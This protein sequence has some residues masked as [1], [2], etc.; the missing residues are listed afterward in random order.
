MD[1]QG[2]GAYIRS[3]LHITITPHSPPSQ[4]GSST[5]WWIMMACVPPDKKWANYPNWALGEKK[6][7]Y[8][9][10]ILSISIKGKSFWTFIH[11]E[12]RILG[13]Y[14]SFHSWM[15]RAALISAQLSLVLQL[16]SD[17][18]TALFSFSSPL[19]QSLCSI[20][21][22]KNV[23]NRTFT[24]LKQLKFPMPSNLGQASLQ[25]VQN[26]NPDGVAWG[27]ASFHGCHAPLLL[28]WDI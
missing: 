13:N 12:A 8:S 3:C 20:C 6:K 11:P 15:S 21:N 4:W 5:A 26:A 24:W 1:H 23:N 16:C 10:W 7:L 9:L 22:Q 19:P 25:C 28:M 18:W 27:L 17:L 14:S 2:H